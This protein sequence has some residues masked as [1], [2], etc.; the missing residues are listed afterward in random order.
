MN[1]GCWEFSR[2]EGTHQVVLDRH[3][4]HLLKSMV[5]PGNLYI[6]FFFALH[7]FSIVFFFGGGGAVTPLIS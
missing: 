1:D 4:L 6:V 7:V 5:R 3:R 2:D